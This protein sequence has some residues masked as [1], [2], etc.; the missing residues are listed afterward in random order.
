MLCLSKEWL[1]EVQLL[2]I[3][4]HPNLVK[5]L[6]YCS[7]DRE[8]GMQRLLVY[9][10]M[11]NRSLEDHLFN[12]SL[13]HLSWKTR[14][15]IMLGAAQGLRYL[16]EGLEFQDQGYAAPEYVKTGHLKVQSD[17]WSFGVVLYEI[18]TGR[19]V[20]ERKRPHGEQKLLEWKL[21]LVP[22]LA[23]KAAITVKESKD[24]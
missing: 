10:F 4:D 13:P 1:A 5:L 16:H 7:V 9:G 8:R 24:L 20:L 17:I 12:P 14:L 2:G 23:S 11:P 18:L 21:E 3:V 22:D 15:Q 19:R 6:G